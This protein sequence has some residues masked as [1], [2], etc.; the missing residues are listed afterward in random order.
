[1]LE[2]PLV[3]HKP[4]K[5]YRNPLTALNLGLEATSEPVVIFIHDDVILANSEQLDEMADLTLGEPQTYLTAPVGGNDGCL[6]SIKRSD[7]V[8]AGGFCEAFSHHPSCEDLDLF[9]RLHEM[10][11]E[12]M[13]YGADGALAPTRKCRNYAFKARQN[14]R[15]YSQR[16]A[17]RCSE[18]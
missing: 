6:W 2:V 3:V 16:V 9:D 1:M 11:L 7:Y 4:T 17:A 13:I 8:A 18:V 15:L 12:P 5:E 14:R 10:G